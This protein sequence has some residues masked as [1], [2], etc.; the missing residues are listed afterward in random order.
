MHVMQTICK[1]LPQLKVFLTGGAGV[2]KSLVI[3]TLYQALLRLLTSKPGNNPEDCRII[4][5]A[6]TGKAA[7][8]IQGTTI[9]QALKI[10][11]NRGWTYRKPSS[12]DLNALRV[13]YRHLSVVIIDEISM[14]GN[15]ALQFINLR[16]QDIKQNKHPFGGVPG[17]VL[18]FEVGTD[19]RPEVL[20]TTL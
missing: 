15:G 3:R 9:H 18:N 6:P 11:P 13:K 4:L 14:V 19:L 5:C 8:N 17:G 1:N 7:F 10:R 16:L 20:I 2:G 12:D